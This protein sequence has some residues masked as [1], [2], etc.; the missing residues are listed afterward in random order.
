MP[1]FNAADIIGKTLVAKSQVPLYRLPNDDAEIVYTVSPGQ[2]LGVVQSFLLPGTN[3]NN[4]YWQFKDQNNNFYYS[5]HKQGI[6]DVKE[7]SNQGALTLQQQQAAATE[8]NLTTGDKIFRL[9]K[10]ALLIGG[11]VYLVNT[12]IKKKL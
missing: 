2:S 6:Y 10:N 12:I 11:G 5:E 3:R 1:T 8:A 9:I 7:L 4:L